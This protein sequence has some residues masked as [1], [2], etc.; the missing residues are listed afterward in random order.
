[1]LDAGFSYKGT[2]VE[3]YVAIQLAARSVPLHY[4]REGSNGEVD[5]LLDSSD[6]ILPSRYSGLD[7]SAVA[8]SIVASMAATSACA[9]SICVSASASVTMYMSS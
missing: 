3:N 5:F 2:I 1:M 4:W 7:V 9:C 8:A 6:G